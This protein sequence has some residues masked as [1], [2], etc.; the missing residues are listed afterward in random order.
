MDSQKDW[1]DFGDEIRMDFEGSGFND[2]GDEVD[3]F[4]E[5]ERLFD[6]RTP[7]ETVE[8]AA[9]AEELVSDVKRGNDKSLFGFTSRCERNADALLMETLEEFF[10]LHPGRVN[11]DK[12]FVVNGFHRRLMERCA[13]DREF[14]L[15]AANDDVVFENGQCLLDVAGPKR[16]LAGTRVRNRYHQEFLAKTGRYHQEFIDR[17]RPKP[18][19]GSRKRGERAA[20]SVVEEIRFGTGN[21]MQDMS[22]EGV[23]ALSKRLRPGSQDESSSST[24]EL[25]QASMVCLMNVDEIWAQRVFDEGELVPVVMRKSVGPVVAERVSENDVLLGWGATAGENRPTMQ[26]LDWRVNKNQPVIRLMVWG[27]VEMDVEIAKGGLGKLVRQGSFVLG[28][29]VDGENAKTCKQTVLTWLGC[30]SEVR[31]SIGL[32]KK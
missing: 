1:L 12:P 27:L 10:R 14:F 29:V 24:D 28:L 21:L 3:L 13:A 20:L 11:A 23:S 6:E 5:I 9:S 32:V 17:V 7:Q 2:F 16:D 4:Q 19:K 30:A 15:L 25:L 22:P 31:R 8:V 18:K 26:P